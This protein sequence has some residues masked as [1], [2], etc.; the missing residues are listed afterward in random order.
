MIIDI[1][2]LRDFMFVYF[3]KCKEGK[4]LKFHTRCP[5]CGDSKKNK[6]KKRFHLKYNDG[7]PIF[8]CFNCGESNKTLSFYQLYE[9]VTGNEFIP[10]FSKEKIVKK[11]QKRDKKVPNRIQYNSYN[12]ILESCIKDKRDIQGIHQKIVYRKF[13][14]FL[15]KRKIPYDV[16]IY[17]CYKG[18]YSNRAIIPIYKN[19]VIIYFQARS[20]D[21]N[22]SPK[23]HSPPEEK[24]K[25]IIGQTSFDKKL[26]IIFCEGLIDSFTIG[27]QGITVFGT[28]FDE[29]FV[30]DFF[31]N[32][33]ESN[34][35]FALD[36]DKDGI[37][38]TSKLIESINTHKVKYYIPDYKYKDINDFYSNENEDNIFDY[39]I[40]HSYSREKAK[41]LLRYKNDS[42]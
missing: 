37:K 29:S 8:N 21:E 42:C 7:F 4:G 41:I 40:R 38:R 39:V 19:D 2:D 30:L 10:K 28:N 17:P 33:C 22:L 13:E 11:F 16:K 6:N 25:I 32:K 31:I 23:Y 15:E 12:Y 1:D 20:L 5:L 9:R 27:K 18:E 35:I 34:I 14:K 24:N 3:D 36:N 26:P